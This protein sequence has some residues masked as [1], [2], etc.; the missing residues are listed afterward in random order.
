ME[1]A[2]GLSPLQQ[3]ILKLAWKRGNVQAKQR[4][5]L[6]AQ[7][8]LVKIYG[9]PVTLGRSRY[10]R[11]NGL[12]FYYSLHFQPSVIGPQRYHAAMVAVHRALARLQARGLLQRCK[13]PWRSV[14]WGLTEQGR[15]T[16]QALMVDNC[17]VQVP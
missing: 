3:Q 7:E 17:Y 6:F 15:T 4:R 1:M 8:I 2:R 13:G 16:V 11:E 12:A 9:F 10:D 14:G 5:I